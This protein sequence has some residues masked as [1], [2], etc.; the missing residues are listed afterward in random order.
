[1]VNSSVPVPPD[2]RALIDEA[3]GVTKFKAKRKLAESRLQAAEKNLSRVNDILVE[4]ERQRNSLRRQAGKA[5]R[6][7]EVRKRLREVLGAV[8]STRAEIL[9]QGQ[10]RVGAALA[11]ISS[12]GERLETR[13]RELDGEVHRSRQGVE[14]GEKRLEAT[15]ETQVVTKLELEKAHQRIERFQDQVKSLEERSRELIAEKDRVAS[16]LGVR[17]AEIEASAR[18]LAEA[19]QSLAEARAKLGA[20]EENLEATRKLRTRAEATIERLRNRRFDIVGREA[21][22]GNELSGK[23][24]LLRRLERQ[25]ERVKGEEEE[26]LLEAEECRARLEAAQLEHSSRQSEISRLR[27]ERERVGTELDTVSSEH[28]EA[29][30]LAAEARIAGGGDPP[31]ARNDS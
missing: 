17:Q 8:F 14:T 16:D 29:F 2:R 18:K 20:A 21:E 3:A 1:M 22:I 13:V 5:R 11:G 24:D 30:D 6:Y 10:E 9:I 12:E 19:D 7:R 28:V 27:L 31:Q 15:R 25:V 4:V 23:E 26:A